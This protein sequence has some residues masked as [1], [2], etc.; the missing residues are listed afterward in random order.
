M[1]ACRF[2]PNPSHSRLY[3]TLLPDSNTNRLDHCQVGLAGP[4]RSASCLALWSIPNA[5]TDYVIA[6]VSPRPSARIAASSM[7]HVPSA[8]VALPPHG[9]MP[10]GLPQTSAPTDH[11]PF[12]VKTRGR[13]RAE[14][15]TQPRLYVTRL[16]RRARRRIECQ[17]RQIGVSMYVP[18]GRSYKSGG[19]TEAPFLLP[20]ASSFPITSPRV[21]SLPP[22]ISFT[23]FPPYS[24]NHVGRAVCAQDLRR[25]PAGGIVFGVVRFLCSARLSRG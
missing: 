19:L 3:N 8:P 24:P 6:A 17:G 14:A 20:R 25:D 13:K 23:P 5:P 10:H 11:R 2:V 15:T 18:E 9:A 22:F 7:P 12:V 21:S 4:R 16:P 1:L